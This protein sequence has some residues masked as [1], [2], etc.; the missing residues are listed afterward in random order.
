MDWLH[1]RVYWV[2]QNNNVIKAY[3]LNTETISVVLKLSFFS[4][5]TKL[6]ILP[7]LE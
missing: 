7:H 3:D 5:P 4:S 2:K 6:K 1:D